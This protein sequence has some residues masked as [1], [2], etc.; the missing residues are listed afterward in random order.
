MCGIFGWVSHPANLTPEN[1][2]NARQMTELLRHRGPDAGGEWL[3]KSVYMGHRRLSIIDRS[4]AA[5]QPLRSPEGRYILSFNGEIYNYLELRD[6]LAQ[7]GAT[8]TTQSDTEVMLNAFASWGDEAL[9]RFDGM[10]AGAFHDLRSGR[11]VIFRDPMGQKPLYYYI[12]DQALIYAS[13]LRAII[14]LPKMAWRLDREAFKRFLTHG[15]Y[16]GEETPIEGVRKLLPGHVLHIENGLIRSRRYWNSIPGEDTIGI[17]EN[18]AVSEI[19]RLLLTSCSQAMR[20]DVSYGVFLSGGIDSSLI[21][22]FCKEI[23][24][25]ISSF[26]VAMSEKDFDESNKAQIVADHIGVRNHRVVS[27]DNDC[28]IAAVD[29]VLASNDEPH[30]DPGFVNAHFLAQNARPHLTVALAGDGGDELF[31]GY[32]PFAGV[33]AAEILKH[34]PNPLL[35]CAKTAAS[36]IPATDRY[37]G[38]SFKAISYL[39]GFPANDSTRLPLWLATLDPEEMTKLCQSDSFDRFGH[40]ATVFEP[41]VELMKAVESRTPTQRFLYFYQ[42]VFL[43]EFVCMHTD[44]AAMQSSLEVRSPFLSPNLIAFANTLPD[45]MKVRGNRLKWILQ[46][47]AEKRGLPESIVKQKKQGFTFPLARWMKGSLQP[48]VDD[49]LNCDEWEADGL[50]DTKKMSELKNDH[51]LGIRNNYRILYNLMCFRAW[52]RG[53][54]DIRLS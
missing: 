54:S 15:Y 39:R 51:M 11:H 5:N 18:E 9:K 42:K 14:G 50:I 45:E 43:P 13:E 35:R 44:R 3:T 30:G 16:S 33:R 23:D 12:D 36:L 6:E 48:L 52:R 40:P 21:L 28:V 20:T 26:S 1:I 24:P 19:E 49:L 41:I 29:D 31:G 2:A 37:V 10:F 53:F 7:H 38:L 4:S 8:F 25:D 17:S 32:L 34:L 27:M 46:R 22:N 47:V